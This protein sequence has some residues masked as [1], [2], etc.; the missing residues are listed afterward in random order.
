MDE[1]SKDRERELAQAFVRGDPD[2]MR[3]VV[4]YFSADVFR[5]LFLYTHR[6]E[7]AEDLSQELFLRAFRKRHLLH[8][9]DNFR[10]WL[11]TL[12]RN[13]AAKEMKRHRYRLEFSFEDFQMASAGSEAVP[14]LG[15]LDPGDEA[16]GA[17]ILLQRQENQAILAQALNDV[18][19]A[20][21]ELLVLRFFV[22]L[23]LREI[24]EMLHIPMGSMGGKLERALQ[25]MRERLEAAGFTWETLGPIE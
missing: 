23:P 25:D 14:G 10:A 19:P 5:V 3:D 21:R 11:L 1:A 24:S 4:E 22:G 18:D 16:P 9:T 8:H 13:L 17:A 12:A 6:R 15:A 2:A 7:L 20:L